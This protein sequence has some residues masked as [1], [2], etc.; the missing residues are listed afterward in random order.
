MNLVIYTVGDDQITRFHDLNNDGEADF[1]E[2]FNNDW[3]LTEAFHAFCFDLHSG[4]NGDFFFSFGSP[5]RP[6]GHGF[7][8]VGRHHGSIIRVSADGQ[9]MVGKIDNTLHT[10]KSEK[11]MS[12]RKPG[13]DKSKGSAAPARAGKTYVYKTSAGKERKMEVYFPP[14]HNPKKS[15]GPAMIFFHGGA[16]LGG[17]LDEFRRTCAYFASRGLVCATAN[18]QMLKISKAEASKLSATGD[19]HKRVCIIDAKSAIRW[20]KQQAKEFGFDPNRIITG[21]TSA[22]GHISALATMNPGLNDPAD[23][24]NIDTNVVAYIWVNPAFSR[25]DYRAPEIDLM[26]YLKADMPPTIAFWGENDNWKK[27]WDIAYAKWKSLGTKS[28]EL[29]IA[30]NEDHGFWNHNVPWQTAMLIE[31]DKFLV[32]HGLLT[33]EPTLTMDEGSDRFTYITK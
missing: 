33:G 7:D 14:N 29:K 27:G 32:K 2:N 5:V 4:L 1:Y 18:Y 11:Q 30:R 26:N 10:V 17:S 22:G 19:T 9:A 23:P 21:G 25:G 28:I 15:K 16:W 31:T 3:E 12:V 13:K 8:R 24:K 6:G 20:F